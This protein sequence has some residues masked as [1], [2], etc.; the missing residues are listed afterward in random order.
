MDSKETGEK[1]GGGGRKDEKG[2]EMRE[3][4]WE[5]GWEEEKERGRNKLFLFYVC[6]VWH[7]NHGFSDHLHQ[8]E[9]Y[10]AK[11]GTFFLGYT[12]HTV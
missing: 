8:F 3:E 2:E 1:G 4:K 5:K 10:V 7:T 9:R 11:C 12:V 6:E